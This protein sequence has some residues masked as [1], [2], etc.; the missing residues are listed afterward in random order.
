MA[1]DPRGKG[2]PNIDSEEETQYPPPSEAE[3]RPKSYQLP[4]IP[5]ATG[6]TLP[7]INDGSYGPPSSRYPP[8]ESTSR[9]Q[10]SGSPSNPNGYQPPSGGTYLPPF[11]ALADQRP[12]YGSESRDYHLSQHGG[13][14][15]PPYGQEQYHPYNGYPPHQGPPGPGYAAY[16]AD[17]RGAP[18][19]PPPPQA[20]PRQRTSI[21]CRY[22]RKRKIRCSGYANTPEGKCTNCKKTGNDCVFQPVSSSASTAFIPVSAL[23][24]GVPPGTPLYGAFGQPLPGSHQAGGPPQPGYGRPAPAGSQQ[25]Y[26]LPSPTGGAYYGHP[27][28]RGQTARR[29]PRPAEDEPGMRLP[30]PHPYE[31]DPRD[32]RRRSPASAPSNTPP[33]SYHSFQ[34]EPERTPTSR[35]NS[36]GGAAPASASSSSHPMSLGNLMDHPPPGGG[37]DIDSSM[38]GRLNR[39]G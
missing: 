2:L 36:P 7:S 25:D 5:M 27:D 14:Q 26:A 22:C 10:Y 8:P 12:A 1:E 35:R 29:R 32:P 37:N 33:A 28:D 24:G 13:Q 11:H 15:R 16:A 4:P 19:G 17:Y 39:R 38:L 18:A 9:T 21:A 31:E 3:E 6:M 30:P 34:Y 20:A 23:P